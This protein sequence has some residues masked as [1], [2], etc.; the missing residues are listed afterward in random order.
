MLPLH[1]R[2]SLLFP[3]SQGIRHSKTKEYYPA[4]V[5]DKGIKNSYCQ[6]C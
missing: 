5:V 4:C 3:E 2:A 1:H 6:V